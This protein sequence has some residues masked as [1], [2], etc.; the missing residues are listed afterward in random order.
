MR[1][2]IFMAA[3]VVMPLLVGTQPTMP[4]NGP[5]YDDSAV[6]RIDILINPDTLQW[7]YENVESTTEFHATFIFNS[8][9]LTD[10]VENIGF[11]LRGNTLL[12]SAKK[13]FKLSFNTYPPGGKWQGFEK[14]NLNGE[15]NDP[16]VVRAKLCWD[17]LRDFGIPAP[18][19]NHVRV[20]I[21]GSYYGLYINV[22]H[23]DEQ[24]VDSRFGNNDGNLY[25][26]LW[27]ADLA[28][29]G[30]NP[31][32]Y[33]V[34]AGDRRVY[35][36]MTNTEEDDYTDLA[37]F[38]DVLN[39]TPDEDFLCEMEK[40]FN[41]HDYLKIIAVDVSTGNWD[42]Y[43]Y[44]KNNF[45]LY[46]NTETGK[47]E[48]IPYDLDNTFGID[49]MG[50]DWGTRNL[51]DW[52]QHGSEVRPLYTRIMD[53]QTLK[54]QFS[55]YMQDLTTYFTSGENWFPRI[56]SL[57]TMIAPFI[58][59][60]PYYP[61]DYGFTYTDFLNS[62]NQALWGHVAYGIKP[63]ILTRDSS[64][65]SQLEMNDMNPVIKYLDRSALQPGEDFWVRAFVEDE[66]QSPEVKLN[67][68]IN[69][70]SP[71]F[72][73][74]YD[75]GEHHDHEPGD[76]VYGGLIMNI[77][78]TIHLEF[79]VSALDN[80]GYSTILPCEPVALD[81]IPSEQPALFINEFLADNDSLYA[82]EFGEYDD[83]IE[84]YNGDD[85]PV[86]LGD[87]FLTDDLANFDKWQLPDINLMPGYFIIIWAD[88]DPEQGVRHANFKL[89]KNGE[90][91][92]IFDAAV[93]G[94]MLIDSVTFGM[95][96]ENIS[97]GRNPDGG[98]VWQFFSPPTPNA[99]NLTGWVQGYDFQGNR[100]EVRP[101]PA[102]SGKVFF[103]R[104][105]SVK[106]FDAFGQEVLRKE[107]SD[108]LDIENLCQGMYLL[109]TGDGKVVKLIIQ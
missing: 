57:R 12:Y 5:V 36:L 4:E 9:A 15:H 32:V 103:N 86:W 47:F 40:V 24:F 94:Y 63:Y 71:L 96:T 102:S 33:K 89:E 48:Y 62:Y 27:P 106:V 65:L 37:H 11:R 17:L 14:L 25:K 39:N 79:Q 87:K 84:I 64:N 73:Y 34:I 21:N 88:N 78:E 20:Y 105:A 66:D 42:G 98:P 75:D 68:T 74:M 55:F 69:G 77:P 93:T 82:D 31:D 28:Y 61:L 53:N 45:Y 109:L 107:N 70:G 49:W 35:E 38:I 108:D 92:G 41:I 22:E 52:E 58:I 101:N 7:I 100:F 3:I 51:Y 56:D 60:D 91:I 72:S 29:L 83:W 54:D 8:T 104:L 13:S 10:T 23:V 50:K 85:I 43:I 1:F 16:S 99:G 81:L 18:R 26:C 30:S 95:Q 80:F 19:S 59:N 67:Y 76:H 46:H 97:Y 2:L 6:P 90:E 44:N